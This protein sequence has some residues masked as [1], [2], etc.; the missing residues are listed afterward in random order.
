[1]GLS[2]CAGCPLHVRDDEEVC[3]YCGLSNPGY[4]VV[5]PPRPA[6]P[7][8]VQAPA[9]VQWTDWQRCQRCGGARVQVVSFWTYSIASF[10]TGSCMLWIPVIGWVAAPFLFLASLV[11]GVMAVLKKGARAFTCQDCKFAWRA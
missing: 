9:Q 4:G 5:A 3:P 8:R 6:A 10:L 1:M 2:Q 7:E 11:F